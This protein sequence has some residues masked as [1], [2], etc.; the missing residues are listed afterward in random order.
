MND[1][2][3][4]LGLLAAVLSVG[5]C[6]ELEDIR[7]GICGNGVVEAGEDCDGD[8]GCNPAGKAGACRF[9]CET[10]GECQPGWVC[11]A[12]A[13]CRE[14]TGE[15]ETVKTVITGEQIGVTVGE[16]DGSRP[17]D[18]A[19][20][21]PSGEIAVRYGG[22]GLLEATTFR[23]RPIMP[24]AGKLSQDG[25]D[26]L[27]HGTARA[28]A[29]LLGAGDRSL[30]PIAYSP[31]AVGD[32]QARYVIAEAKRPSKADDVMYALDEILEIARPRNAVGEPID[33]NAV[34]VD[35]FDPKATP[36]VTLPFP[37]SAL[38]PVGEGASAPI[39]N[40]DARPSSPC[41]ELVLTAA[42][43]KD[44]IIYSPCKL[45][46]YAFNTDLGALPK[47]TLQGGAAVS[48][49]ATLADIDG[50]GK[51]DLLVLGPGK[52]GEYGAFVAF[53]AGDGTFNS[54]LPALPGATDNVAG[55]AGFSV[56]ALPLAAGDLDGDGR[57][58]F[59][60]PNELAWSAACASLGPS[61]FVR[62]PRKAGELLAARIADFNGNGLKDLVSIVPDSRTLYFAD[63]NKTRLPTQ[64][65]IPTEGQPTSL[66]VGDFDG[67]LVLDVAIAQEKLGVIGADEGSKAGG[68]LFTVAFGNVQGPPAPPQRMGELKSIVGMAVG[69]LAMRGLDYMAD[70]GVLGLDQSDTYS[71]AIFNGSN[72]RQMQSPFEL[73]LGAETPDSPATLQ[74]GRFTGDKELDIAVL[75]RTES[76]TRLWIAPTTGEAALSV[77][78]T[79]ASDLASLGEY[80]EPCATH[81]AP[82]D[83][84]QDGVDE[85][86]LVSPQEKAAGTRVI[87]AKV[88][89]GDWKISKAFTIDD[90]TIGMHPARAAGC[91]L[92]AGIDIGFGKKAKPGEEELVHG[93]VAVAKLDGTGRADLVLLVL[94]STEAQFDSRIVVLRGGD[95][96]ARVDL[97]FPE[98]VFP[99]SATFFNADT[100]PELELAYFGIVADL[101]NP[102]ADVGLT[103]EVANVDWATGDVTSRL[104][105]PAS[106]ADPANLVSGDFDGDGVIDLAMAYRFQTDLYLGKP[107]LK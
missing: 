92:N 51:L 26:D 54:S 58:D 37:V 64:H 84:D 60:F 107:V 79:R 100:D 86:F 24:V 12:D 91:K 49:G 39:G 17:A 106:S 43:A 53:G 14:P 90:F 55:F 21:S 104:A 93:E 32:E 10:A 59:V 67:D 102:A 27:A 46:G 36:L 25:V 62:V 40:L 13:I 68:S 11:G 9:G 99:F 18:I 82:L 52:P 8:K 20:V 75:G 34:I 29:V 76:A 66:A 57:A 83:T 41:D 89:K 2:A 96:A 105:L 50:D 28:L 77:Q 6:T 97:K 69:N 95:P 5:A 47:V 30:R 44:V 31:I 19:S 15:F 74:L 48:L 98:G 33:G 103:L 42:G 4:K 61:C 101:A 73:S 45:D 88:E 3:M 80:V 72:N 71:V 65:E 22:S 38:L 16:L 23:S 35:S 85:L 63:G 94:T 78:T 70:V 1:V 7:G 87:V 56:K 81:L